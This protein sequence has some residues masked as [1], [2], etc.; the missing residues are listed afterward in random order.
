MND[1]T[2]GLP[3]ARGT[4]MVEKIT[5]LHDRVFSAIERATAGWGIE[6]GARLVFALTLLVYYLN[7][8]TT[9]LG[10]GL[11]GVFVPSAGAF[12]QILPPIAEQYVYDTSAIPF[13]PWHLIVIAGT[14]AEILLPVLILIGLFTRLAA[15][16]MIGFV[17]VQTIVDVAFHSV[18]LGAWFNVQASELL[19][20]RVLW[21]F[22][23]L[24]LVIK[25]AGAFSVD[26]LWRRLCTGR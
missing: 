12:A 13:F 26:A 1:V 5:G 21:I 4:S 17:V 16:G 6:F 24:L 10:D 11:F 22:L 2:A 23:L 15:L 3:A 25:G 9:K 19:D 8:A 18:K 20:Q 14:I 7:S